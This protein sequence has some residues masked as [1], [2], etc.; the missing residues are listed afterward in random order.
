MRPSFYHLFKFRLADYRY[1]QTLGLGELAARIFAG[2]DIIRLL[3]DGRGGLASKALNNSPGLVSG[4]AAEGYGNDASSGN[5]TY[6]GSAVGLWCNTPGAD[7]TEARRIHISDTRI[8]SG[9]ADRARGYSI[10]CIRDTP[11]QTVSL[12]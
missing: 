10:R 4:K 1:T 5:I 3:G 6:G 12:E 7:E 2:K 11:L 8:Q 9:T